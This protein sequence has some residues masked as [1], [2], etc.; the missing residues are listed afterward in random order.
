MSEV[1]KET[2]KNKTPSWI[3]CPSTVS[4]KHYFVDFDLFRESFFLGLIRVHKKIKVYR[5]CLACMKI[6]L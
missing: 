3:S 5:R 2:M 4:G 6:D 1:K